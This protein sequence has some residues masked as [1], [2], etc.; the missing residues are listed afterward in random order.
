MAVRNKHDLLMRKNV[1]K[2]SQIGS[3]RKNKKKI[4]I[5]VIP[6]YFLNF[7]LKRKNC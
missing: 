4:N 5:F 2:S 3:W 1:F 6:T 7:A